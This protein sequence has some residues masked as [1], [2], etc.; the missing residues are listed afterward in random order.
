MPAGDSRTAG[1]DADTL[2]AMH[3]FIDQ[4]QRIPSRLIRSGSTPTST[5]R[6]SPDVSPSR[7]YTIW[8]FWTQNFCSSGRLTYPARLSIH[9]HRATRLTRREASTIGP[10]GT[11]SVED[12]SIPSTHT[13]TCETSSPRLRRNHGLIVRDGRL[14]TG[15]L[16]PKIPMTKDPQIKDPGIGP[17]RKKLRD[18]DPT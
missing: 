17:G 3:F 2:Y 18:R 8:V 1:I 10:W 6:P 12:V 9:A 16:N 4:S 7:G 14:P 11:P 5:L 13:V 15:N